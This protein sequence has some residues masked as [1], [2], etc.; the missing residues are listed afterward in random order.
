M[1]VQTPL[2]PHRAGPDQFD[3]VLSV[4]DEAAGWLRERGVDQWPQSFT[5]AG[6]WRVDR[7]RAYLESETDPYGTWLWRDPTGAAVAVVNLSTADPDFAHGWPGGSALYFYRLAV[8]RCMAGQRVGARVIDWASQRASEFGFDWLRCDVHR[9][10]PS[11]QGY[12]ERLDFERVGTVVSEGI[13]DGQT[14]E[15]QSGALYQR[16]AGRVTEVSGVAVR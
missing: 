3:E 6:G 1:A 9:H 12:Y 14:Y 16:P 10:N 13:K 5:D 15:R 7:I 8:R 4:L 2:T 11:L